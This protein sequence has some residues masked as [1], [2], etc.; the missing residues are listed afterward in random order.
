MHEAVFA[1]WTVPRPPATP[2]ATRARANTA[3]TLSHQAQPRH[4]V[5]AV[6]LL[7]HFTKGDPPARRC[8]EL[9]VS[10]NSVLS[11]AILT[12]GLEA[13]NSLC[14]SHFAT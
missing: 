11:A 1:A 10:D 9:G 6:N 13:V 3:V 7:L 14:S 5:I 8:R 12:I 4:H 2:A